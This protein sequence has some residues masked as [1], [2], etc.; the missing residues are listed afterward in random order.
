MHF[1]VE[2]GSQQYSRMAPHGGT[3]IVVQFLEAYLWFKQ[4]INARNI[5]KNRDTEIYVV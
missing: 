5:N 3:W 1:S 2:A 4:Q